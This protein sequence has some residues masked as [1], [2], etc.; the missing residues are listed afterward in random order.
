MADAYTAAPT[1]AE[2]ASFLDMPGQEATARA[3]KVVPEIV[4]FVRAYTRGRGFAPDGTMAPE[5]SAVVLTVAARAMT[6]PS[7]LGQTIITGPFTE[8]MA[9]WQGFNLMERLT[10]DRWRVKAV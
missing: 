7:G 8:T 4:A 10:L 1:G 2:V 9:G 5:I 3:D 6:N